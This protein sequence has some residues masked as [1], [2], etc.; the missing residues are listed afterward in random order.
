VES[1]KTAVNRK[2]QKCE[3]SLTPTL[4]PS[5]SAKTVNDQPKRIH[6]IAVSG[7][8]NVLESKSNDFDCD[9]EWFDAS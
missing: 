8:L 7:K 1:L 4:Q 5:L 2:K 3:V 6:R 9:I